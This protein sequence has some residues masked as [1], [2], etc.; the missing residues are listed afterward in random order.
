MASKGEYSVN[1]QIGKVGHFSESGLFD[2][3]AFVDVHVHFGR[4]TAALVTRATD[5][6]SDDHDHDVNV[7]GRGSMRIK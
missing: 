7:N 6:W 2:S 4:L 1:V 3:Q 5:R